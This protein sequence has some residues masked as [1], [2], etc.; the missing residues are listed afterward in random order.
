M[1]DRACWP[2]CVFSRFPEP[3]TA[4]AAKRDETRSQT[5]GTRTRRCG[6]DGEND[7]KGNEN[8]LAAD[9]RVA[10]RVY[11]TGGRRRRKQSFSAGGV[12]YLPATF[13]GQLNGRQECARSSCARVRR[14]LLQNAF[15]GPNCDGHRKS[16][17]RPRIVRIVA[18]ARAFVH[19]KEARTRTFD[20]IFFPP[21]RLPNTSADGRVIR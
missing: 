11:G 10:V 1:A 13:N 6:G 15:Q 5:G 3:D 21:P 4:C 8:K 18:C 14:A 19:R 20:Y 7:G 17:G 9:T 16:H 2:K 12:K